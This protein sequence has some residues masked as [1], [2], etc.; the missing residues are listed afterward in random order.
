MPDQAATRGRLTRLARRVQC[1]RRRADARRSGDAALSGDARWP[2]DA[3]WRG[4]APLSGD[5]PRRGVTPAQ[6]A[7][8]TGHIVEGLPACAVSRGVRT[9]TEGSTPASRR[10]RA[11]R[12]ASERPAITRAP[13]LH[14]PLRGLGLPQHVSLGDFLAVSGHVQFGKHN[15][16]GA[17]ALSTAR[18]GAR[19]RALQTVPPS[20]PPPRMQLRQRA[21]GRRTGP[22]SA[23]T[24]KRTGRK[25]AGAE[26]SACAP[27]P[28]ADSGWSEAP[29]DR[30][31]LEEEQGRCRG[32]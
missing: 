32:V 27:D 18:G 28:R 6:R 3:P 29:G 15:S 26:R 25:T 19:D 16:C 22:S 2:G 20:P 9:G 21:G 24:V 30:R 23:S 7:G 4:D 14:R 10:R 31:V 8:A 1:T 11:H 5:A 12:R 13:L 17:A